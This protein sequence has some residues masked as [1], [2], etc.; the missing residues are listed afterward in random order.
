MVTKTRVMIKPVSD[1]YVPRLYSLFMVYNK[2]NIIVIHQ[3]PASLELVFQGSQTIIPRTEK[4]S[5]ICL[6]I[7]LS[8]ME[9]HIIS[10]KY[11]VHEILNNSYKYY[12]VLVL[13]FSVNPAIMQPFLHFLSLVSPSLE[14]VSKLPDLSENFEKLLT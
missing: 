9:F 13:I 1:S 14:L 2:V 8:G 3:A 10:A 5:K 4:F 11:C 6:K 12:Q 7:K